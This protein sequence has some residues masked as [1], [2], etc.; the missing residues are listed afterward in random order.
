MRGRRR[1]CL[2]RHDLDNG[3]CVHLH[4][5]AVLVK[6]SQEKRGW[7]NWAV[8]KSSKNVYDFFV[9]NWEASVTLISLSFQ[10]FIIINAKLSVF[11]SPNLFEKQF[12]NLNEIF[13]GKQSNHSQWAWPANAMN[14]SWFYKSLTDLIAWAALAHSNWRLASN[15][16]HVNL[17]FCCLLSVRSTF[18]RL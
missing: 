18:R 17:Q 4:S 12:P 5:T 15:E 14:F 1:T 8:T 9:D 3:A 16:H 11:N 2:W 7:R 6:N 10:H 13:H